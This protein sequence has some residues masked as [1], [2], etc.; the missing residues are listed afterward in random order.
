MKIRH[1]KTRAG[2]TIILLLIVLIFAVQNTAVVEVQ[3]FRWQVETPR[4]VLI[5]SMLS[6]GFAIGWSSRVIYRVLKG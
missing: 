2:S 1:I 4:S 5:F 6:I 3:F